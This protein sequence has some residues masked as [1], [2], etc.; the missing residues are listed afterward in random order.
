MQVKASDSKGCGTTFPS[1][2]SFVNM[3]PCINQKHSYYFQCQHF[4]LLQR[5]MI[6]LLLLQQNAPLAVHFYT[7]HF[8]AVHSPFK[9]LHVSPTKLNF[10]STQ[11]DMNV[12]QFNPPQLLNYEQ[13][14]LF[15]WS[16]AF[17]IVNQVNHS[18]NLTHK[19]YTN[20]RK[21]V[22]FYTHS[23]L[24]RMFKTYLHL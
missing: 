11:T 19:S 14:N 2:D 24:F 8:N 18:Q 17:P 4:P 9:V 21:G 23:Y 7:L 12:G 20:L 13:R 15:R 22:N 5:T 3:A 16:K 6:I 10:F 1:N